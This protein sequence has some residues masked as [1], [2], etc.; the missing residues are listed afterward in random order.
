MA[1]TLCDVMNCNAAQLELINNCLIVV[2]NGEAGLVE[3]K[4]RDRQ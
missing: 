1:W 2:I 4:S 3:T